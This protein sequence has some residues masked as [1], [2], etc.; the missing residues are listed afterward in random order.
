MPTTFPITEIAYIL[1]RDVPAVTLRD[2]DVIIMD[3]EAREITA[4]RFPITQADVVV[5]YQYTLIGGT[6]RV[7]YGY[8]GNGATFDCVARP[9]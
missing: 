1:A 5:A 9:V 3:G 8:C 6:D 4:V 7:N 2:G